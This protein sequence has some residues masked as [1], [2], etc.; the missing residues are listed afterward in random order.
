MSK[1]RILVVDDERDICRALEFLLSRDGYKIDTAPSAERALELLNKCE[2]DLLLSDLRMDGMD[3]LELLKN[4]KVSYP[5]MIFIIMT[6]FASVDNAVE[7][8]KMGADDYIVKPFV[9]DDVKMSIR[10]LLNYRNLKRENEILR[11]ELSN[12][13][14]KTSFIGNSHQVKELFQLLEKVIPT[15][16]NILILGESGTGKGVIAEIIHS[17][18]PRAAKPFLTINC[19]AIPETLLESE[20][21]GYK[22]GAFTGAN[23]DKV[24]LIVAA[25]EGTLFLDE[26]GDMPASLQAKLLKVIESS[27]VLR[28]GDVATI[29]V[30]V[31]II[32]AT[33]KDIKTVVENGTFR[34]DLYY[35]L[36]VI[37]MT[38]PPLKE[39]RED[40]PLLAIHFLEIFNNKHNFKICKIDESAMHE[41]MN[42]NW[43]GNVRELS[44]MIERAVLLCESDTITIDDL[45]LEK[46]IQAESAHEVGPLKKSLEHYERR[47]ILDALEKTKWEKEQA[48][49]LLNIDLATLYRKIKKLSIQG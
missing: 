3:G 23:N 12:R 42:H 15:K 45:P 34:E 48:A 17:N 9:N 36:N 38:I 10:R 40:V 16:S 24:G 28:L 35:R 20:L 46:F 29:S 27:E 43:P 31:R 11:R 21:F 47:V 19:S 32:A 37:E 6:A 2:Y 30:D 7:A 33:N 18:S 22:K 13:I 41:L 26:I 49:K 44:N 5:S 39:R 8:M 25:D 1:N 4:V 14:T